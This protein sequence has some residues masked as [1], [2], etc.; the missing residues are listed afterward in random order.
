VLLALGIAGSSAYG[1]TAERKLSPGQSLDVGGYT[2]TYR[3]L[4]QVREPNHLAVRAAVDLYRGGD[5]V[6]RVEPGKNN[7]FAEKQVSNE[8]AIHTNWLRAEDVDVIAD[9]ITAGGAIYFKVLVQPLV[10]LIWL[11]GL[12]FL[13]GSL[14]ALWPDP[15]EERRLAARYALAQG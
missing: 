12:V 15:R 13:L 2:L 1:S 8:M 6:A 5:L 7:Y 4:A 14:I 3:S 11:A 9:Q 10:N